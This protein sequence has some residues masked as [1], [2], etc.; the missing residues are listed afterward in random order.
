[1]IIGI[2]FYESRNAAL[3]APEMDMCHDPERA[4]SL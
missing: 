1:M 4:L 2:C 3:A